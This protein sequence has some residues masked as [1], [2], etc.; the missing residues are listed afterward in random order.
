MPA[1]S[2][3]EA[4]GYQPGYY[5]PTALAAGPVSHLTPSWRPSWPSSRP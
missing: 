5:P 1:I 2:Y 3:G 4:H